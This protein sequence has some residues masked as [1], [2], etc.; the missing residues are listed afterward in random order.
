MTHAPFP[1]ARRPLIRLAVIAIGLTGLTLITPSA[2]ADKYSDR[3]VDKFGRVY[4][5]EKPWVEGETELPAFPTA[6]TMIPFTVGAVRDMT[7]K[8]DGATV[9]QGAD[10][11]IR[12]ALEI[13]SAEGA[14]NISYE[15]MRCT[16][17]ERRVYALGRTDKTWAKSKNDKWMPIKG[18]S[19]NPYV[20]LYSNF[21]CVS[22]SPAFRDADDIRLTL[23]NGGRKRF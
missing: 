2:W 12:F 18:S 17:A 22:N 9:S 15:G 14:T 8:V 7:F 23:R 21:F 16:T 4:E 19:N 13:Q 20:E 1:S 10:G 3:Y 11:V 5:E 6:E